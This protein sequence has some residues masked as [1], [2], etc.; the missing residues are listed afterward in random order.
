MNCP[1]CGN[2]TIKSAD[3]IIICFNK[4]TCTECNK[5][6]IE[7]E[8]VNVIS[9]K[10]ECIWFKIDNYIIILNIKD[11][12]CYLYNKRGP[13]ILNINTVIDVNP[14]NA[15]LWLNKLLKLNVFS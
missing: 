6:G 7:I 11:N 8:F 15:N 10:P 2:K 1:Y 13:I 5:L 3:D 4:F 9:D 14:I 12:E